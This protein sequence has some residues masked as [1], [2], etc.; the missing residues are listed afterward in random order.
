MTRI[1]AALAVL[2]ACAACASRAP[3]GLPAPLEMTREMTL[4][5]D[6]LIAHVTRATSMTKPLIIYATGDRGWGGSDVEVYRQLVLWGYPTVGVSSPDYLRR[7]DTEANQIGTGTLARDF[8]TII[9]QARLWMLLP[10]DAPAV[11]V[12]VS[13]GADLAVAAAGSG[14]LRRNIEGVVAIGLTGEEEYVRAVPGTSRTD[15]LD[16]YEYLPRLGDLPLSVIQSAHDDY[17]PAAEARLLFGDDTD[18]RRLQAINA[19]DHT[20]SDARSAMYA[21]LAAA[22]DWITA[23]A[24]R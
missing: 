4:G 1:A 3:V 9:E 21:A 15:M 22:L 16:V 6:T 10:E 14:P 12:G 18:A 8:E 24:P 23:K 5:D 20:F 11:L 7:Y 2:G 17:L 19:A 13:R